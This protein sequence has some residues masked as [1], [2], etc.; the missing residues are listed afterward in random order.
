MWD[1]YVGLTTGRQVSDAERQRYKDLNQAYLADAVYNVYATP[2]QVIDLATA[3]VDVADE[4]FG[5]GDYERTHFGDAIKKGIFRRDEIGADIPGSMLGYGSQYDRDVLKEL[6]AED[7]VA[8]VTRDYGDAAGLGALLVSGLGNAWHSAPVIEGVTFELGGALG[9]AAKPLASA[10]GIEQLVDAGG[11]LLLGTGN[12]QPPQIQPTPTSVWPG[13]VTGLESPPDLVISEADLT[14][15]V[16][17]Y[18]ASHPPTTD[19]Q[20]PIV[21]I[22]Q[23]EAELLAAQREMEAQ[24]AAA[25]AESERQ[26][27]LYQQQLDAAYAQRQAALQ[28]EYDAA[29]GDYTGTAAEYEAARQAYDARQRELEAQYLAAQQAADEQYLRDQDEQAR[30]LEEYQKQVAEYEQALRDEDARRQAEYEQALRDEDARRQAEYEAALAEYSGQTVDIGQ[31]Y[32]VTGGTISRTPG[33]LSRGTIYPRYD[34]YETLYD[35]EERGTI[36]SQ[37]G[38][39]TPAGV[40]PALIVGVAGTALLAGIY[41]LSKQKPVGSPRRM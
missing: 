37:P 41:Y 2:G 13:P 40:N 32:P 6:A 16:A 8:G 12:E 15:A 17:S 21:D 29:I 34:S 30:Q 10:F 35:M 25:Q 22:S 5:S 14:R 33:P 36:A 1:G 11:Q 3:A 26:A 18:N 23:Y 7:Y 20:T 38:A 39:V 19:I 31:S 4:L 24:Y 28:G 9:K 27:A